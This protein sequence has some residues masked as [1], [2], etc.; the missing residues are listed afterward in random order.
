MVSEVRMRPVADF[1]SWDQYIEFPSV[2][3]ESLVG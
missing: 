2:I 1:S 3:Y